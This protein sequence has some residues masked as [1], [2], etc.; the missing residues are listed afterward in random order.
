MLGRGP[1][2]NE[3]GVGGKKLG[4]RPRVG[5]HDQVPDRPQLGRCHLPL[6]RSKLA[7]K[8]RRVSNEPERVQ[9]RK[10]HRSDAGQASPEG[11]I[12][13]PDR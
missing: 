1:R 13:T 10:H 11:E 7:K 3:I 6:P 9:G 8:P 5:E 4:Q 12:F 2:L